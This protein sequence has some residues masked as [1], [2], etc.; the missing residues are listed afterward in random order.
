M[1][2]PKGVGWAFL[3]HRVMGYCKGS[4]FLLCFLHQSIHTWQH[5]GRCFSCTASKLVV[6]HNEQDRQYKSCFNKNTAAWILIYPRAQAAAQRK[7][8]HIEKHPIGTMRRLQP[9]PVSL[10]T[11]SNL[12]PSHPVTANLNKEGESGVLRSAARRTVF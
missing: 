1:Q 4:S 2:N 12:P 10:E 6:K 8:D 11:C 3:Q 9:N 7:L 5:E